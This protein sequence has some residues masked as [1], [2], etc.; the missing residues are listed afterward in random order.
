MDRLD[1]NLYEHLDGNVL[2]ASDVDG[3]TVSLPLGPTGLSEMGGALRALT[4]KQEEK[5][6]SEHAGAV[7]GFDLVDKLFS[8][9]GR[10]Q[11]EAF[12]AL[13]DKLLALSKLEHFDSAAGGFAG[14]VVNVLEIGIYNLPKLKR[15]EC[16][17]KARLYATARYLM[18]FLAC[19][20]IGFLLAALSTALFGGAK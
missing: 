4:P 10:P 18:P 6:T 12:R 7:M 15:K 17:M 9:R 14:A 19:G 20:A 8:L 2:A 11:A 13:H 3:K 1:N 5:F 16:Q